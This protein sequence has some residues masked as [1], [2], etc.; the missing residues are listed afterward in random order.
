MM[1]RDGHTGTTRLD[2][3]SDP[4]GRQCIVCDE[5]LSL[6]QAVRGKICDVTDCER[7]YAA[8]LAGEEIER[9]AR[10]TKRFHSECEKHVTGLMENGELK[11]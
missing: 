6:H 2:A 9:M 3:F 10:R 11:L 5:Q 8:V 4:Q 1:K 7:K